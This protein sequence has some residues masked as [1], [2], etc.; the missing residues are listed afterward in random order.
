MVFV[1]YL[2]PSMLPQKNNNNKLQ[3]EDVEHVNN[4]N[5]MV[6]QLAI[7]GVTLSD[8]DNVVDIKHIT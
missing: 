3:H 2:K 5:S 1:A 6:E 4:F 8:D 7:I